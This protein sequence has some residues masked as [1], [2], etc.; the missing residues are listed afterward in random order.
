M[1]APRT[2]RELL[3]EASG[4]GELSTR[5]LEM[6]VD[7]AR[8]K[9]WLR[10]RLNRATIAQILNGSYKSRPTDDTIRAI[11]YLAGVTD[12]VA[13]TAAGRR[14]PGRP[15]SDDLPDG[16]DDLTPKEREAAVYMLRVLVQQRRELN[17]HEDQDTTHS[18]SVTPAD[19]EAR[20]SGT[21]MKGADVAWLEDHR[22]PDVDDMLDR[23]TAEARRQN[24]AD[25]EGR[26]EPLPYDPEQLHAARDLPG[27]SQ[28]ELRRRPGKD[29]G[30]DNQDPGDDW[31][32]V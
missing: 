11:A 14:T 13:F 1:N 26:D 5:Q 30:E 32:G 29:A 2:L 24:A 15:F 31:E 16:V 22:A 19:G 28:G 23:V 8:E 27:P 17:H 7:A 3:E 9:G 18:Q 6:K 20:P 4:Y 12:E 10:S 21:P 25:E